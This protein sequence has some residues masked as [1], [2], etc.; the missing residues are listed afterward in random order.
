M[1]LEYGKSPACRVGLTRSPHR[2]AWPR[3]PAFQAGNTGSNPVGDTRKLRKP[4]RQLPLFLLPA[5]LWTRSTALRPGSDA[6][7]TTGVSPQKFVF[8]PLCWIGLGHCR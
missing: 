7:T 2:L 4:R 8:D 6:P 1:G 3:T 5:C